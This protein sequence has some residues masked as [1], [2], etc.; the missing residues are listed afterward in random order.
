MVNIAK[1]LE[2]Y[3]RGAVAEMKKVTWPTK[4][5]TTTY[6]LIVLGMSISVAV[7]FGILD[8]FFN[9]GLEAIIR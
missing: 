2:D 5:Q 7:F 4:K 3:F 6:S 1:K 9:I 8:Y